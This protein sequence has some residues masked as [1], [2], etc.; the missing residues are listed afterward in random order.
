MYHVSR[1]L[2]FDCFFRQ[3]VY[4][5]SSSLQACSLQLVR[6]I[7]FM[8]DAF[9]PVSVQMAQSGVFTLPLHHHLLL[10]TPPSHTK[11]PPPRGWPLGLW[12]QNSPLGRQHSILKDTKSWFT[13]FYITCII[14]KFIIYIRPCALILS[15]KYHLTARLKI[16]C[17]YCLEKI[18]L[19]H[20]LL[21][22]IIHPKTEVFHYR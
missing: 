11:Q 19:F 15:E 17:Q 9:V 20:E 12:S 8:S 7:Y 6:M 16:Y 2:N 21:Y 22:T 1:Q 3:A 5:L 18:N 4:L 13:N 10:L 14:M